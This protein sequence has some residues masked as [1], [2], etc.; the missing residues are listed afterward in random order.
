MTDSEEARLQ[1]MDLTR[2][3]EQDS[4]L[5]HEDDFDQKDQCYQGLLASTIIEDKDK[6][7]QRPFFETA[8]NPGDK[9]YTACHLPIIVL[10]LRGLGK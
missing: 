5:D 9:V 7:K 4:F 3:E 6:P 1:R 10:I 2:P 8:T